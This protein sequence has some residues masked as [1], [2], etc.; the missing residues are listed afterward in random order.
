MSPITPGTATRLLRLDNGTARLCLALIL[1]FGCIVLIDASQDLQAALEPLA[2]LI[3]ELTAELIRWFGMP[4]AINGTVVSHPDGFGYRV[5]Y[6]CTGIRPAVILVLAIAALPT[7]LHRRG[8][9]ILLGLAGI[10]VLN[11]CRLLHLYWTGVEQT[12]QF[13]FMHQVV[14]NIVA[15]LALLAYFAVCLRQA[16]KRCT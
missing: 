2:E 12:E 8:G 4:V 9:A 15:V 7:S 1:A 14:W 16:R 11:L 5:G 6:L 13:A 3:A 10:T